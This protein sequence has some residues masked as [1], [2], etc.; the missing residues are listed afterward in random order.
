[1]GKAR[2]LRLRFNAPT[3]RVHLAKLPRDRPSNIKIRT[4]HGFLSEQFKLF[5]QYVP[6][7]DELHLPNTKNKT[8]IFNTFVKH[9]PAWQCMLL[10]SFCRAWT[11]DF[12][13]VKILSSSDFA[14]CKQCIAATEAI[15]AVG[16][17][18]HRGNIPIYNLHIIDSSYINCVRL[19]FICPSYSIGR[20]P[21]S[22]H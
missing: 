13:R 12:P 9:H 4:L 16:N 3:G 22:R 8:D 17:A 7:K 20:L 19:R 10:P 14:K 11:R 15:D 5:G 1:V 2:Y 18:E 6:N 21:S